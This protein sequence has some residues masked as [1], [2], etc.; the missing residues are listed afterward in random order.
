MGQV[1]FI[2][3]ES[4][5]NFYFHL[6]SSIESAK[7][8]DFSVAFI[9]DAA[10]QLLTDTF[11]DAQKR[12]VKG[13]II[14]SDY[15][16]GTDPKALRRL[17]SFNNI[18][19]KVYSTLKN[20][21][22][23]FHTKGYYF[24]RDEDTQVTIGS[25]NLT[26][27]ALKS[28]HEWNMTYYSNQ[29]SRVIQNVR[30]E[31]EDL[32]FDEDNVIPLTEDYIKE[33]ELAYNSNKYS[34]VN[35]Q[36]I[37]KELAEF[38]KENVDTDLID[39]IV[40]SYD[41][42][43]EEVKEV[44]YNNGLGLDIKP[45]PM[46]EKALESLKNLRELG[47][48]KG[49]V[50]AAT[51]TGKTYLA[52]FDALQVNPKRLLFIV[53]RE[54]ILK[55]AEKT[56]RNILNVK[57]GLYTGNHKSLDSDYVFASIQTISRNDNL[58]QLKPDT[59]DYIV[60]DE[61]HRSAAPTY[62][63]VIKHFTPKFLLGLTATPERTDANSIFELF[64]NQIAAE[65]RLRDALGEKL[66]VPFHYFGITDIVTDYEG[67]D[68]S[69]D[70]DE[71][72]ER[73]NVKARVNLIVE[74]INKYGHSGNKTKAIGFC[75]NIKHAQ[76][77]AEQF[78]LRGLSAVAL[79]KDDSEFLRDMYIEQL[80]DNTH[81]LNYIFAVDILNEGIDIPSLNLILMLRPTKSPIIFT[82]Q[83]GRGLR[84]HEQKEYL[85]VLDFIG[86]HNRSFMIPVALTGDRA[87][88][89][90]D[91]MLETSR[92][93]M[94]VPGDTFIRMDRVSKEH[95]LNQ[96]EKTDFD[97]K[98]Y[99][100][101]IFFDVKRQLKDR[102]PKLSDYG[103]DGFDP[104]RFIDKSKSYFEFVNSV[105]ENTNMEYLLS[106]TDALKYI[107]FI[108]NFLPLKRVHEFV[109]LD[110]MINEVSIHFG[111][112]EKELY[113]YIS[114]IDQQDISHAIKH[115]TVDLLTSLDKSRFKSP[116]IQTEKGIFLDPNFNELLRNPLFKE[117]VT[118]S[119]QYG[120]N[121]YQHEFGRQISDY[122]NF[123]LFYQ[124]ELR[125]VTQIARFDSIHVIQ[126][127]VSLYE[128]NFYLF[129]TLDKGNVKE[130]INFKD[131]FLSRKILQWESMRKTSQESPI[132]QDL[133]N[134]EQRGI[135]IHL[136]VK[137]GGKNTKYY[138]T[139]MIYLGTAKVMSYEMN[140]P[141]R[142]RLALDH[143]V[144]E[145]IYYRLTTEYKEMKKR[146]EVVAAVI[147]K[148]GK[149]FCAQRK[150][151]GELAK[152]W[153]FPGGKIEANETHQQ[154]LIREIKEELS[155]DIKVN[156]FITTVDHEYSGFILT[157][158]AY[159][160]EIVNG[161]LTISE[162]L[163]SKWLTVDEMSNYDFA[164]ADLPIIKKLG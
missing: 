91:I 39:R 96:L 129:V 97:K 49:L 121:R 74:N 141:I 144:P 105:N 101:E 157:M 23:G 136:F 95:I 21:N 143:E 61:A 103:F 94:G 162:H 34:K 158:H 57:T 24:T 72:A 150:N 122:P 98:E 58:Y 45:N 85:T 108:D 153:E 73:L 28:N 25:S 125:D 46:Q 155:A 93:F 19:V 131:K 111:F 110:M 154:A 92:D 9:S 102:L 145:D 138:T 146:I 54:K 7:S 164:A 117:Y 17:L 2:S 41:I 160:C 81:S 120:I 60:I 64:D 11:C 140:N 50:I 147:Q 151:A 134:H 63:K 124:Y 75:A 38:L 80:E 161:D 89:K 32:W 31:F 43:P 65:I 115:L 82:Q 135:K 107:R 70:I 55:E 88:D 137:K 90:E 126:S 18:Q 116:L 62:L 119:I 13:R 78:N 22:R 53:H 87:Y 76:Y 14:T 12:G 100:E 33:Y 71:M 1:R 139:K 118:D 44:I 130:E 48:D 84:L 8:F 59:F 47:S 10:I 104:V 113:K 106:N 56:F 132:G 51:G 6:I 133:I 30:S 127:G 52:A 163:D 4:N 40:E 27:N 16:F 15:M 109:I 3:N 83:L 114:V 68:I 67:I 79:T 5:N 77:M 42:S 142:F 123:K 26:S 69:K 20:N 152:K 29:N 66:V 148:D 86:N 156:G 35:Q 149:Y 112:I 36:Q 128:K 159:N 37:F 99:L